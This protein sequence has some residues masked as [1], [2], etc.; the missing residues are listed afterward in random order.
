MKRRHEDMSFDEPVGSTIGDA[1][2]QVRPLSRSERQPATVHP[3]Q[4]SLPTT[5]QL[6][7][8]NGP[9]RIRKAIYD[10]YQ[11]KANEQKLVNPILSNPVAKHEVKAPSLD[12]CEDIDENDIPSWL[13]RR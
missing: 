6:Q 1:S 9:M 13:R 10:G 8:L 2:R 3:S 5:V 11:M 7:L 12:P 4:A